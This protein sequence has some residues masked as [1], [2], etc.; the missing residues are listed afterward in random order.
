M[1]GDDGKAR[2]AITFGHGGRL[3]E[4]TGLD[5]NTVKKT[6]TNDVVKQNLS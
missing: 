3:L 4:G 2:G 5:M 6:I 1:I